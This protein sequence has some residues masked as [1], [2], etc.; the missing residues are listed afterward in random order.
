MLLKTRRDAGLLSEF[1]KS[2]QENRKIEEVQPHELNDFLSEFIVTVKRKDGGDHEPSSLRG[3]KVSFNR[4]LKDVMYSKSI[5]EDQEFEQTRKALD[6]RCKFLKKE[7][8]GN[9]PFAA[10]AISDDE[11][12]VL[13]ESNILGI[14][15]AEAFINTV[16]LMNSIHFGLRGCDDYHQMCW[17]DV[18]LLRDADGTEYLEYCEHRTK[19]RSGE[20]PRNI[21]PVKLKAFARPDGPPEEDPVFV[22]KFYSEKRPSSMQTVE[23]PYYLGINHS[24]DS[25]KFWFKASPMG[26]NKN[27]GRK[28]WLRVTT[29]QP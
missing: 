28:S 15:S 11:V 18:K 3:F 22:Y 27:N 26:V 1:S 9:R 19:T 4:H 8:R 7:G 21:R 10:E 6:A 2:K 24:K 23:A 13:Y 29:N 16:W 20:E 5:V 14:S 17:S 25:S 12:K